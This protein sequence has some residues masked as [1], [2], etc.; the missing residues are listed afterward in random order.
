M[1][2]QITLLY[3]AVMFSSTQL[4]IAEPSVTLSCQTYSTAVQYCPQLKPVLFCPVLAGP[5]NKREQCMRDPAVFMPIQL[6]FFTAI[7]LW[8]A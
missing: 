1:P 7:Q 3:R 6:S 5:Q 4:Y 8:L 2:C